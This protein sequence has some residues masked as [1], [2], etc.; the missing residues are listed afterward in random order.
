MDGWGLSSDRTANAPRIASTPNIDRLSS[1]YPFGL[2]RASGLAVGLP[3]GQMGNSEVG[4]LTLGAGRVIYQEITR[5]NKAI[6]DGSF[7]DNPALAALVD[8]AVERGG[9]VHLMGLVSDGGVHSHMDHLKALVDAVRRRGVDR[10]YIHAFL[11]GRD[12][13]P[14][15]G[16]GYVG[17]LDA[18][19]KERGAGRIATVT[20]RYWAMDR[21]NRWER[22][23]KAY[24]AIALGAGEKAATAQEAVERAYGR[25]ETDEFVKPTVI[26][27][28]GAPDSL[29][30]ERDAIIFFNFRADRARELT[31]A[32]V[33][34]DFNCFERRGA[35]ASHFLTMTEYSA[36]FRL[37]VMFPPQ[38]LVNILG[39]VLASRDVSQFRV[40]ETE[41]YAHVTFF[42]NGGVETPFPG[43]DRLLIPSSRDVAT[44]DLEPAMRAAEI[45][46]AAVERIKDGSCRFVLLNFA[47]GD[48]VG[49]T[50]VL[51]AAVRA[52]EAVDTALGRVVDAALEKGWAVLVTSDHGNCEQMTDP[53]T[54]QPHTAHTTNPVPFILVD[55]TRKG[56]LLRDDGGLSDIAP[57][58]LE[59][60]GLERPA[61]MD[62]EVL[63]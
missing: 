26:G 11:D 12:T 50:G 29:P 57:T 35:P 14:K 53:A 41:K 62:G 60:M 37:P 9:A 51:E 34:R 18:F 32:F 15:S 58:V 59:I 61:E 42:F 47:N 23:H 45:A 22:V 36:D 8:A 30:R 54:G 52:C 6:E 56:A 19:L 31:R 7:G 4:H 48:M 17:E 2:L 5:I 39:E 38:Q 16:L 43:E 21:D 25:G 27:G 49:H 44:Y 28:D 63:F 40:S 33:E 24:D 1:H 20:G 46:D 13:P 55:E 3:E 10:I